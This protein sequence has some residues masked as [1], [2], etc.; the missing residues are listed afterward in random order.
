MCIYGAV[1]RAVLS[2]YS[3]RLLTAEARVPG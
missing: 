3:C 1:G 2:S